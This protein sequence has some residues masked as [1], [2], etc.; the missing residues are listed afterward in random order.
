M[1]VPPGDRK[2]HIL[3]HG[4]ARPEPYT[5]PMTV[6]G[7][8]LALPP[9]ERRVQSATL[10]AQL[11]AARADL[12]RL[13]GARSA[14]GIKG[15]RGLYLEFRSDPEF[16]L[17]LR[18]LDRADRRGERPIE[19]M[20]VREDAR[21]MTTT[22]LVPEGKLAEF[23][24]LVQQYAKEDTKKGNPKNQP[25]IDSISE[26][27]RA[28]LDSFWTDDPS[29]WPRDD[30]PIWWEI[31]LRLGTDRDALVADFKDQA[32]HLKMRVG[33]ETLRFPERTV[34]LAH[35]TAE[36]LAS[37]VELLDCIAELRRAKEVASFF[38]E[39]PPREQRQW[40]DDLR[41]RVEWPQ[42]GARCRIPRSRSPGSAPESARSRKTK[43]PGRR[44]S[45]SR[46]GDS[47]AC[48]IVVLCTLIDGMDPQPL[49]PTARASPSSPSAVGGRNARTWTAGSGPFATR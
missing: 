28:A 34:L 14:V 49:W 33:E 26:I 39:M 20:A 11:H 17:A 36:Q 46:A 44:A 37:S 6:R 8:G 13:H 7:P 19:L 40:A 5:Y 18:S 42:D 21:A 48:G 43:S 32:R 23:E 24:K 47:G 4:T 2:P 29:Q 3:V 22:V 1:A 35:G 30:E 9:R 31:W 27:R 10:L 41:A 12:S 16:E 38:S 45:A 25:L 15:D